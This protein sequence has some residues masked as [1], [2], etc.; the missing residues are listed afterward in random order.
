MGEGGKRWLRVV[1]RRSLFE[2]P[3]LLPPVLLWCL[4][5]KWW[6][7][8]IKK[9]IRWSMRVRCRSSLRWDAVSDE[10]PRRSYGVF[11]TPAHCYPSLTWQ[12]SCLLGV[13]KKE[14][15]KLERGLYFFTGYL[16]TLWGCPLLSF[17]WLLGHPCLP[18]ISTRQYTGTLLLALSQ[19]SMLGPVGCY[20][21]PGSSLPGNRRSLPVV[22]LGN[23]P[24]P[25]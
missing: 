20:L 8:R 4:E 21:L 7:H 23:L 1:T 16:L 25:F 2:N 3:A 22:R 18:Y 5:Y 10:H 17:S 15:R 12:T 6:T 9:I 11:G 19:I 24:I 13:C 14:K